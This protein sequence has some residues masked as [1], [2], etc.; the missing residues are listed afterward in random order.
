[1]AKVD[2]PNPFITFEYIHSNDEI[3]VYVGLPNKDKLPDN[4]AYMEIS[5]SW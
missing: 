1:M 4:L 2:I 3:K 5:L